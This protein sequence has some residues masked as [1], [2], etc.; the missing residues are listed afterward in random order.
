MAGTSGLGLS[1]CRTSSR[2]FPD[3]SSTSNELMTNL[4][5]STSCTPTDSS[6]YTGKILLDV[7]GRC[8]GR[9]TDSSQIR[10]QLQM[11]RF[12][13]SSNDSLVSTG[14]M[15][16]WSQTKRPRQMNI[17]QLSNEYKTT[18]KKCIVV[19]IYTGYRNLILLLD[20]NLLNSECCQCPQR[21]FT[22]T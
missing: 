6:H 19:K 8:A 16:S 18:L 21:E 14:V 13:I 15:E 2:F 20:Q 10:H 1:L 7:V 22:P 12:P 3:L 11:R 4:V 17:K 9:Y 5:P